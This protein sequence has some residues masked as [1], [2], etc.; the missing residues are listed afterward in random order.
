M[1]LKLYSRPPSSSSWRV[2]IAL[3]LVNI[4]Y[5][6]ISI[7]DNANLPTAMKQIPVLV[8][9]NGQVLS[10]S[11]AII[12]YLNELK[13]GILLGE[14]SLA[15][16]R[17]REFAEL[18]NSGIQPLQN[19]PLLRQLDSLQEGS[20]QAWAQE[21]IKK[22]LNA[23]EV[24]CQKNS[25]NFYLSDRPTIAEIY[26]IPQLR[27]ARRYDLGLKE[28]E[29]LLRLESNALKLAAFSETENL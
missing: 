11:M 25:S 8:T 27:N 10:Q 22:G 4:K 1:R 15:R 17:Q 12:E 7:D 2:R 26:L 19:G 6:L 24:L 28:F 18:V 20:G 13:P 14:T 5:E 21:K 9:D 23:L 16:A 3:A 29:Q